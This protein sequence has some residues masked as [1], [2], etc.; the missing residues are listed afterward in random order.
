MATG[1]TEERL[2]RYA[3]LAVRVGANVQEGQEVFL[4]TIPEHADIARALT[5]QCYRAGASYVNI[6]YDDPHLR[7]AMIGLGPDS[8]L[9]YSPEWMQQFAREMTGNAL[10]ATTGT[11]EPELF[12]DLDGDRVGRA[13]QVEVAKIRRQQHHEN[14]VNWCG[15]GAPNEGW[16]QQVLGE[17]DVERLWALVATCFRLDEDDPVAAWQEHLARLETRGKALTDLEPDALHYRGPGTDLTVGL[18]SSARWGSALFT[19]KD[20]IEYVANMPTEEIFTTPDAR[21]AEGTIRSTMPLSFSGQLIRGL[22]FTLEDGKIVNVDAES[23]AELIRSQIASVENADRLGEL[24][25]VTKESRVGQ[26]GTLYYNTLFDENA[27]CHIAFGA[28][29]EYAF[30]GEPDE[31]MNVC[32]IHV[33]FMIGGPEL[34]VD[35]ILA[36]GSAVPLIREEAWQL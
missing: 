23:G 10:L 22:E 26:T 34:E 7:H 17:P 36:D 30:D 25:L 4:F 11:P 33:D 29:L 32:D 21:R 5:R 28:G 8:A 18:L 20:G 31:N 9:T 2:E 12:A 14:T 35:A 19:T 27:T 13:M 24:A 15:I 6:R 16:A 3:E 1:I